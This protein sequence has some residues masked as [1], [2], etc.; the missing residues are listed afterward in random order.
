MM[1][2]FSVEMCR[3]GYA[4][5]VPSLKRPV[6]KLIGNIDFSEYITAGIEYLKNR[7]DVDT[8]TIALMGHSWGGDVA[9][10]AS[11]RA[12]EV[13]TVIS[14][15]MSI[16][17][18]PSA[19]PSV[20]LA[21]GCYDL[22]HPPEEMLCALRES[23]GNKE[24]KTG[25][26][27][28]NIQENTG[29]KLVIS[30]FSDHSSEIID[31]LLIKETV[32]WLNLVS[33]GTGE[34]LCTVHDHYRLIAS[35]IRNLGLFLCFFY[36]SYL[37]SSLFIKSK[38]INIFPPLFSASCFIITAILKSLSSLSFFISDLSFI[39]F[40]IMLLSGFIFRDY[41]KEEINEKHREEKF[42]YVLKT[43]F[44]YIVLIW[45]SF[46]LTF[47]LLRIPFFMTNSMVVKIPFMA[48]FK[49]FTDGFFYFDKME[50]LL[51]F[52][53]FQGW[54]LFFL[55]VFPVACI[56]AFRPGFFISI[57]TVT[58]KYIFRKKKEKKVKN[59]KNIIFMV[60]LL[61]LASLAW[62]NLIRQGVNINMELI[63]GL[64]WL[65]LR[66]F[67]LPLIF[68]LV[69]YRILSRFSWFPAI[70]EASIRSRDA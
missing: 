41:T 49:F 23:S 43:I 16:Y 2:T 66:L 57:F 64:I 70:T 8:S 56:E 27:S 26:I 65:F 15:G 31:P 11:K 68:F 59:K 62:F 20:L 52:G 47:T 12:T 30:P 36:I 54:T 46:I 39:V 69:F 37:I 32:N 58:V 40:Q 3:A 38:Y 22:L 34:K 10:T 18:L 55:T 60:I 5:L 24:Q 25:E 35:N 53:W 33:G 9:Y 17:T 21:C 51:G 1:H 63:S 28:G 48:L 42:I 61:S 4:V 50:S 14:Y 29:R 13:K 45:F 7:H 19:E 67:L 44:T 6:S